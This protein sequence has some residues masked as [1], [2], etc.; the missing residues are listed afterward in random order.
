LKAR[1]TGTILDDIVAGKAYRLVLQKEV[2]PLDKM[3]KRAEKSDRPRNFTSAIRSTDSVSLIAEVKKASPSR[4]ILRDDFEPAV[5]ARSYEKAGASAVS[6]ITEED[7]FLGSPDYLI[8][9]HDACTLPVLRKDFIFD[10]YQVHESRA[11]MADAVLL[12]ASILEMEQLKE[13]IS[14]AREY[15]MTPLVE[16]HNEEEMK[17]AIAAGSDVIG[18]NNRNL[19]TMEVDT[20]TTTRLS[21]LVPEGMVVVAESGI[22]SHAGI[23]TLDSLGINA[24]LVGESIVSSADVESTIRSLLG[25][26]P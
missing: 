7:F 20:S 18:I 6:V 2:M 9:V 15:G 8:Q 5:L 21:K 14:L 23:E 25:N 10:P 24:V 12:I 19:K 16:V 3:R 17:Q 22:R 1:E 13:L 4:G 11:L 26:N